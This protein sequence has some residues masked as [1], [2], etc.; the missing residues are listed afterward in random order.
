MHLLSLVNIYQIHYKQ[1][2]VTQNFRHQLLKKRN[3]VS[4]HKQSKVINTDCDY[5]LMSP[6]QKLSLRGKSA[7]HWKSS[8]DLRV[9]NDWPTHSRRNLLAT[10]PITS[11]KLLDTNDARWYIMIID[12]QWSYNMCTLFFS[13]HAIFRHYNI[14]II[15]IVPHSFY[16]L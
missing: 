16:Y 1:V 9:R 6:C 12:D 15:V 13:L 11:Y 8:T 14:I 2:G 10:R 4:D 7:R 3:T 5:N